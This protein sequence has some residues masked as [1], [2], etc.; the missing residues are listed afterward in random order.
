MA[1]CS[2]RLF[3]IHGET[4]RHLIMSV[5]VAAVRCVRLVFGVW[6]SLVARV[7]RDDEVA[8]SNPVTPTR[9]CGPESVLRVTTI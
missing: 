6:R 1:R 5:G 8:G 4:A 2:P 3:D 7:V 9:S